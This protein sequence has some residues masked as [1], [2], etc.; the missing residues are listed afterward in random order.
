MDNIDKSI[1][2]AEDQIDRLTDVF[3]NLKWWQFW[4]KFKCLTQIIERLKWRRNLIKTKTIVQTYIDFG[5]TE[6]KK[7]GEE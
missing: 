2:I 4:S 3:F 1:E 6:L 5:Y 7:S